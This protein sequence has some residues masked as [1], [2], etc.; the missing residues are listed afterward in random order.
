MAAG[1]DPAKM[2]A[3]AEIDLG[4]PE[5]NDA[6]RWKDVW[7]AGQG[8]AAI[9]DIPFVADLVDRLTVEYEAA[10]DRCAALAADVLAPGGTAAEET[11]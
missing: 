5:N 2:G 6:K 8:V 3:K 4:R 7:S 9:H 1:F 11:L 10:R